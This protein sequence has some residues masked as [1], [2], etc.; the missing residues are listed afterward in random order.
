LKGG[1][2]QLNSVQ[3]LL[4]LALVLLIALMVWLGWRLASRR[5]S[6]PCPAWLSWLVDNP[7]ATRRT[8]ATLEHLRLAPGMEVLDAGCGPGRL[9][10]PMARAIAP[11]GRVTAV[12]I[13]PNMI[14]RAQA[15]ALKAQ[16]DNIEFRL[17]GLGR[18]DLPVNRFDRAVLSTVLGEIPDRPAAMQEIYA[19]LK[20]GGFLLVDE[21][22]GDPHYQPLTRVKELA[23]RCGL[24]PGA[25]FGSRWAYSIVL[26]RPPGVSTTGAAMPAGIRSSDP[27]G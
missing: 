18:G 15:K 7:F 25:T 12:D 26:E 22:R 17:T 19:A 10:I 13:Q 3:I 21:V 20:P 11:G 24:Q 1:E 23:V 6:I 9:T 2:F 14:Q 16:V 27:A 8:Q 4:G 5:R